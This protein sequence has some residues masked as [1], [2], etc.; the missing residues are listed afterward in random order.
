V[1]ILRAGMVRGAYGVFSVAAMLIFFVRT[2]F[3]EFFGFFSAGVMLTVFLRTVLVEHMM[4]S[5]LSR[6]GHSSTDR[7]RGA[8]GVLSAAVMLIFFVRTG[9]VEQIAP[10]QLL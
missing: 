6:C 7:V 4:C 1:D 10:Y 3:V 5:Q 2:V 9:F 8:Y